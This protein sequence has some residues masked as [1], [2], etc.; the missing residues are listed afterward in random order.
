MVTAAGR[1]FPV[2]VRYAGTGLPLLP[3]GRDSP[4][5]AVLRV[6]RR[7][8]A[9]RRATCWCS[10]RAR[11]RSAGCR[12]CW[13]MRQ[14]VD[15]LPLF[16][17]LAAGEQDA[18]LKPARPGRRKIVLA[19]NIAETSLTIDGVRIVVDAGLERRS[20]FDP[21]SGMNR[22]EVQ[23]ISRASAEQRAGRAGRTAPG[24]CYRLWGEGAERS[25]AAYAPPE[26]VCRGP[27][28][29]GARPRRLGHR[30][31][32]TA[33]AGCAAGRDAGERARPAARLGALDAPGKVTPHGRAMQ[34]FPAHPRLAHM[35]L[36]SR[37]LGAASLA[38][39][40]AAL[41][42]DRDLLRAGG[43][44]ARQRR[45]HAPRGAAPRRQGAIA[46]RSSAYAARSARSNSSWAGGLRERRQRRRRRRGAAGWRTRIVSPAAAPVATRATSWPT[47]AAR[48][49]T[50]PS[51]WRARSSSWRSISTI[52]SARRASAW[53]RRSKKAGS[54]GTL[55]TDRAGDELTW[56]EHTE[57]VIARR[58]VR[59]GDLLIEEKPLRRFRGKRPARRWWTACA[60]SGS[61]S[62]PGTTTL[63]T[64]SRASNSCASS[65][66]RISATGRSSRARR[67]RGSRVDRAI[68]RWRDAPLTARPRAAARGAA[69]AAH[70]R[71]AAQTR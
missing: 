36:K 23:R 34:E 60:S 1:V 64:C 26:V 2:E 49:S 59:L 32:T 39:E 52:A 29:A 41:L 71:S 10:C 17:E 28:A 3:G 48:C 15:V 68:S 69:R 65:A 66:A 31:R 43:G 63:A 14:D 19:T 22:L 50:A 58:A 9:E 62:C 53:R 57:A 21:S 33:L 8:L 37:E 12:A 38:A 27:G 13:R 5:L 40:L 11:A 16:G 42:S 55:A 44:P 30:R 67:W 51:R 20:L 4:E 24:V 18:A 35:L 7:A 46:A 6:I 56:D 47:V 70:L 45:A 61:P 54:A 25:L